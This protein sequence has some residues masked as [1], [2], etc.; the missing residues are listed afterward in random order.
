VNVNFYQVSPGQ[1]VTAAP[2]FA[3]QSTLFPS[4]SK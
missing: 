3:V 4:I 2:S 1:S